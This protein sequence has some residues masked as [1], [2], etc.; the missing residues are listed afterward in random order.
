L[1]LY[2]IM[3]SF[4]WQALILMWGQNY[5]KRQFVGHFAI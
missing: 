3:A 4:Y 2:R 1:N 5:D